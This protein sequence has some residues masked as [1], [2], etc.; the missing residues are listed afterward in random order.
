MTGWHKKSFPSTKTLHT[1]E[2]QR[3]VSRR[4]VA[5]VAGIISTLWWYSVWWFKVRFSDKQQAVAR[6]VSC[7]RVWCGSF[8][9][10]GRAQRARAHTLRGVSLS[11]WTEIKHWEC[12]GTGLRRC[13]IFIDGHSASHTRGNVAVFTLCFCVRGGDRHKL[14]I[15]TATPHPHPHPAGAVWTIT[16]GVWP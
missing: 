14:L 15:N 4:G 11:I 9:S 7:T 16:H 3:G 1:Q 2:L 6:A 12:N 13:L 5:S 10:H 8:S